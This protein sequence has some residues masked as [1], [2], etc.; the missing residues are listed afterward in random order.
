MTF[1]PAATVAAAAA[2]EEEDSVSDIEAE[3]AT[4]ENNRIFKIRIAAQFKNNTLTQKKKQHVVDLL[5]RLY[6]EV[7]GDQVD[8]PKPPQA[9]EISNSIDA[10]I[11]LL[12]RVI[13][14]RAEIGLRERISRKPHR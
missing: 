1:Y 7:P 9:E 6:Y 12:D 3:E 10:I 2:E 13:T 5:N 8:L 14:R 4:V 11:Y